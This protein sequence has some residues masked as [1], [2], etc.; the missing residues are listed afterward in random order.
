M[1][2]TLKAFFN[3]TA[4]PA[5]WSEGDNI[6]WHEP[7]FSRRMLRE[8]LDPGHDR[9]SRRPGIIEAHVRWIHHT[10]LNGKPS[11]ILDLGCGPGL[12]A[13]RL[14]LRGHTVTGMD[15]SPASIDYA[16]NP[17][18]GI[19]VKDGDPVISVTPESAA[20]CRF[21]R[22]DIR[23]VTDYRYDGP[24]Y[25]L[26]LL[27]YGEFNVFRPTHA[28]RIVGQCHDALAA[29]GILLLEPMTYDAVRET[30]RQAPF[31]SQA[32]RS[33][34]SDAPHLWLEEYFWDPA[35]ETA[36]TRYG[37]IDIATSRITAFAQTFQA[38]STDGLARLL[39]DNNL[40]TG[41][42][43][44]RLANAEDTADGDLMVI[45]TGQRG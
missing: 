5:P 29:G 20:R 27:L 7:A 40:I 9:A 12:Y 8:H 42:L 30:G 16:R 24:P 34:F 32:T 11:R 1:P 22:T 4:V 2:V 31:W 38:W 28:A 21:H 19:P 13:H 17:Y 14:A 35:T 26:I 37:V 44:P 36:T 45:V 23:D 43:Y 15:Y 25:D 39:L 10:L 33:V 6:P 18:D 41:S 3:R